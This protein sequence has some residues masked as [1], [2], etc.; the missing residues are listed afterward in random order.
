MTDMIAP[1]RAL[2]P[3][4]ASLWRPTST[5]QKPPAQYCTYTAMTVPSAYMDDLIYAW[6]EYIYLNLWSATDPEPMAARIRAAMRADGWEFTEES[7]NLQGSA[8][9]EGYAADPEKYL[10]GWTWKRYR[11]EEVNA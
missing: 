5:Q 6:D 11:E 4:Y 9:L 2:L 10:I 8:N 3:V 1:I 7:T